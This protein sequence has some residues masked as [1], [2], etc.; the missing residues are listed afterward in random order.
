[1]DGEWLDPV[2][3]VEPLEDDPRLNGWRSF[4]IY[5]TSYNTKTGE[6]DKTETFTVAPSLFARIRN[7]IL[8]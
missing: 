3:N 7:S 4:W 8:K 1:M 6:V 2:Y 5:G